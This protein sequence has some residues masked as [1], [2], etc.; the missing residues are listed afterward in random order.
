[1]M[2]WSVNLLFCFIFCSC[3]TLLCG[4]NQVEEEEVRPGSSPGT[5]GQELQIF[6]FP[7]L[8][9]IVYI[10]ILKSLLLNKYFCLSFSKKEAI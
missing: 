10:D 7:S 1:M 3:A 8:F 6:R 5:G 2:P 9:Y 4:R